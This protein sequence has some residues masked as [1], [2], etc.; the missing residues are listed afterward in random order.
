MH[1]S[2]SKNNRVFYDAL[3]EKRRKSRGRPKRYGKKFRLNAKRLRSADESTD[4]KIISP[5]GKEL[6]ITI[7]CWNNMRMRGKK[8][9]DT[10]KT[11]LRLLRIRIYDSSGELLFKRPMWLIVSGKKQNELPLTDV[12]HIYRQRFDIEHFFKFGKNP[13]ILGEPQTLIR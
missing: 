3:P 4:L 2:R 11:P 7:E 8:G 12:Y 5:K 10:S 6:T 9:S 1:V 13:A